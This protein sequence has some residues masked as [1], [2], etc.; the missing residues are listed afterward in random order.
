MEQVHDIL[1]EDAHHNAKIH[2][3]ISD[4]TTGNNNCFNI[5]FL[6]KDYIFHIDDIQSICITYRLRFL[7]SNLFKGEIPQEAINKIKQLEKEHHT[8]LSGFKIMAPSKLF[9]LENYDDP[10]LFAPIGNGYYYLIHKWGN[11]LSVLRKWLMYPFRNLDTIIVSTIVAAFLIALSFPESYYHPKY[12]TTQFIFLFF[13]MF[14]VIG[15]CLIFFGVSKGKNFN[16]AI[17]NS[18][19]RNA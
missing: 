19:Y 7:D 16:S 15:F 2:K 8:V 3:A 18:W 11:D 13:F 17:W 12:K 9:K 6:K 5:D 1:R 14:K 4:G 10:L